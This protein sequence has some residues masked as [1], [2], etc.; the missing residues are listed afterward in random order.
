MEDKPSVFTSR[1]LN[2]SESTVST[3]ITAIFLNSSTPST[4]E[5]KSSRSILD[6]SMSKVLL[7]VASD[8]VAVDE[9][10][11]VDWG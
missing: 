10:D 6:G 7:V 1:G 8:V 4:L 2:N 3:L 9:V 11:V 5:T